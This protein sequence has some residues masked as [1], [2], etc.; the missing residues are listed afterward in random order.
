MS[1]IKKNK[2]MIEYWVDGKAKPYILDVNKGQLLGLRGGAIH[3]IPTAVRHLA[4]GSTSTVNRLI[5]NNYAPEHN[6]SL[7]LVADKLDSIG[8]TAGIW[9]LTHY[10]SQIVNLDFRKLANHLRN[11][12][13]SSIEDY[14]LISGKADWL[15][16]VGL[17]IEG[18]LTEDMVDC[19]YR[20]WREENAETIKALAYCFSRGLY[21]FFAD[22]GYSLRNRVNNMLYWL[23]ELEWKL[24][25]SDFFRQ[26]INARRAY[27]A[28]KDEIANRKMAEYQEE[29]RN[30]LTFETDTHIVIIPTTI[31]ELRDEGKAQGNCVG[32]YGSAVGNK[33]RNVVFIRR[34]DNPNRAYITCDITRRGTINQYL[35][36]HNSYV[37]DREDLDFEALYQ[38]HL[39]ENWGE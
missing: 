21:E 10:R 16:S 32:G 9:E 22:D 11:N 34:K 7:Y 2:G 4:G 30:A 33:E 20:N 31:A 1:E 23:K 12:P 28:K 8:Y 5:Y 36:H 26:Y 15:S 27:I 25:K 19:I 17:K 13:H 39:Y 29:R 6:A 3:S 37:K 35:A 38:A 24:D 18:Q 14:I